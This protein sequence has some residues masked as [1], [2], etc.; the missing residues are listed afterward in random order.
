MRRE[1]LV[2]QDQLLNLRRK[3]VDAAHDHHVV[4][5]AG[6][7]L[8]PTHRTRRAGQQ[9][10]EIARAI[11]DDR[12]RLLGERGKHQFA[13]LTVR[14]H[15][16]RLGIDYLRIEMILPD[17]QAIFCL[18]AFVGYARSH[19]LG[20]PVNIDRMHVE[21]VFDLGTHRVGP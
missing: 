21:R 1:P 10:R 14:Q 12:H 11:A 19:H 3:H 13:R 8:D 15:L 6:D 9:A 7:L 5:A 18:D 17:M 16:P 20:E 2:A 4:R